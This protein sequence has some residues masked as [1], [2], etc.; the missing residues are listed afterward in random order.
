[1][2]T[3]EEYLATLPDGID[4][5]PQALIKGSLVRIVCRDVDRSK[6]ARV[7]PPRVSALLLDPPLPSA[8]TPEVWFLAMA[9]AEYEAHAGVRTTACSSAGR[10]TGFS[11]RC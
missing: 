7:L 6:V 10:S 4:S 11:S 8:W 9:T 1:M 5:Y 3:V 2:H